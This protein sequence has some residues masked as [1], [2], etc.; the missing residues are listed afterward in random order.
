MQ[1]ALH[2]KFTPVFAKVNGNFGH[3]KDKW[4][5]SKSILEHNLREHRTKLRLIVSKLNRLTYELNLVFGVSLTK[6]IC[7]SILSTLRKENRLQ[8]KTKLKKIR[9]HVPSTKAL[10]S[11]VPVINLS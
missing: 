11:Y 10:T 1:Q 8:I 5:A 2:H 9:Y 7:K 3:T 4:K 6:C